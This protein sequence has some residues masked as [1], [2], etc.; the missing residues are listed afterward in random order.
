MLDPRSSE[1]FISG[2]AIATIGVFDGVHRGHRALLE[3]V[4]MRAAALEATPVAISF[5]PHPIEILARGVPV[6]RLASREQKLRALAE[7]GFTH[8][9]L[10]PFS[11]AMAAL[12]PRAFLDVLLARLDLRE[13]WV[14]ADFRFGN[15]RE[16]TI[17]LLREL[18]R[19]RDF[20]AEVFPPVLDA[21]CAWSSSRVREAL[22]R[23]AVE[24]ASRVLGRTYLLEGRV[25]FGR[26]EG[27]KLL[28]PTANLVF[29]EGTC[30]PARG[31]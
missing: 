29:P 31:V 24:E 12:S 26:G 27:G 16:G 28:V 11:P 1:P 5:H 30:L 22:R 23:G 7:L 21:G 15:R 14:G 6:H 2:P 13:L 18:G 3:S 4:L 20:T 25:G 10:L 9:W 17:D 19:E 8:A